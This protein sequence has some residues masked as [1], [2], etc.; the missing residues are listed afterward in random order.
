M[1]DGSRQIEQGADQRGQHQ[2]GQDE[3]I[4]LFRTVP[5][6][7]RRPGRRR[8][9]DDSRNP[10]RA[11]FA[12][13]ETVHQPD[14]VTKTGMG[15]VMR[16]SPGTLVDV[17]AL[18]GSAMPADSRS[19]LERP[20]AGVGWHRR[21]SCRNIPFQISRSACTGPESRPRGPRVSLR[22]RGQ[23]RIQDNLLD[24]GSGI[25]GGARAAGRER[26]ADE[27]P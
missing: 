24:Q 3:T 6:P 5:D 22:S 8:P 11:S 15:R 21:I 18:P 1:P 10:D 20:L 9:G 7:A 27:Q 2:G 4:L 14:M 26:L 23:D 13:V 12:E 25:V 17:A 19:C 16:K